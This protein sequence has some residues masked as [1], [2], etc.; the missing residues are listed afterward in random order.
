VSNPG[1]EIAFEGKYD[2]VGEGVV[3]FCVHQAGLPQRRG[4]ITQ[5]GQP[6]PQAAAGGVTDSHVLD[7]LRGAKAAIL[8]IRNRDAMAK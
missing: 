6:S 5:L 2:A 3:A 4:R 1:I 8:Q 7:D